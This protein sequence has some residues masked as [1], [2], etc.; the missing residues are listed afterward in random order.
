[1]TDVVIAGAARTA[2]GAFSGGLSTLSAA[3]LGQV[4]ISA[5]LQRAQVEPGEVSEIIMGQV[6]TAGCGQNTARQ[7]AMAAGI[8]AELR[9]AGE[10]ST[11]RVFSLGTAGPGLGLPEDSPSLD[12]TNAP[13]TSATKA[14]LRP[15]V[16]TDLAQLPDHSYSL[17]DWARGNETCPKKGVREN[18]NFSVR[19]R[20]P[21]VPVPNWHLSAWIQTGQEIF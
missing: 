13:F 19:L 15:F 18:Q 7:A 4:A 3:E 11:L 16:L 8:P 17:W 12:L 6:L 1:M 14:V 9:L 21:L 20:L 5:A 2:I 10:G